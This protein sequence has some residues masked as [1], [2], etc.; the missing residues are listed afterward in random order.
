MDKLKKIIADQLGVEENQITESSHFKDDLN[1]DPLSMADLVVNIESAF[2]IEIPQEELL[3]FKT[4]G[5][6]INFLSDN[7]TEV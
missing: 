5:D 7:M 4:V 6:V 3:K 2:N 1:A